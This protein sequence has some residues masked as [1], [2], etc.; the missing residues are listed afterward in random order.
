MNR[1]MH[2]L[3]QLSLTEA[4][5]ILVASPLRGVAFDDE[6]SIRVPAGHYRVLGDD[7]RDPR[8]ALVMN[9][10]NDELYA[11]LWDQL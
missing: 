8:R 3:R 5:T 9:T 7:S 6:K 10:Q 11:V 2:L 4:K 1:A